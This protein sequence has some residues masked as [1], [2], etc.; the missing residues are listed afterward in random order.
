MAL[1]T[2]VVVP[3]LP[4]PPLLTT[5]NITVVAIAL[6]SAFSITATTA[7]ITAPIVNA[8]AAAT[9]AV[10][11]ADA[12]QR[13]WGGWATSA[14]R[15]GDDN[16]NNDDHSVTVAALAEYPNLWCAIQ[17]GGGRDGFARLLGSSPGQYASL[18][19]NLPIRSSTMSLITLKTR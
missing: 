6:A 19:G 17:Y 5:N 8:T 11:V 9:T 16:S 10:V 7:N 18:F 13:Q 1:Q 12:Q 3:L 14:V 15:D 4:L 2:F